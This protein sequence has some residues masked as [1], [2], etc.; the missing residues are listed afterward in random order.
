MRKEDL[1]IE[2]VLLAGKIMI[3]SG[4]DMQ[5]VDDT[6][7]RIAK[8]AGIVQPKIFETTTGIMMSIPRYNMTQI[9]PIEKRT[10]DLEKVARVNELSRAF[11]DHK[12]TL[13][14]MH[15]NLLALSIS[16][17]FFA[18]GWQLISAM[19]IS[20]TLDIMY[21]ASWLDFLPTMIASAIGFMLM[22]FISKTFKL[23]F[24]SEFVSAVAIGAVSIFMVQHGFGKD[25]GLVI[26]G[27][28]MPL[29]PGVPITNAVRDLLAGHILSG[30]ARGAEAILVASALGLGIAIITHFIL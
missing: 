17:P 4:S 6:L 7:K 20:G 9:E 22:A 27:A 11:Q 28:L 14:E 10:I 12:I 3:E 15:E 2:T 23:R 21:G 24:V 19:L 25:I 16:S 1:V 5:R 30:L 26:V 8:N 29:V 18:F 13:S